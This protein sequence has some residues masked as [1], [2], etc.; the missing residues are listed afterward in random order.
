M[1]KKLWLK[2]LID[3]FIGI[4]VIIFLLPIL[5][6][7][8]ILIKIE[9]GGKIFFLQKRLG[10]DR[11][12]FKI[13]KFRTMKENA[14]DIRLADG[15]T[16]NSDD[17]PRVTKIGKFLRRTSLDEL[18]Q[19]INVIKGEMSIIGPR[20]D[21]P[22]HLKLYEGDEF[23]KLLVRPGITGYAQVNG[24]NDLPWKER[25]KYDIYY[26]ENWSIMLDMKIILKTIQIILTGKGVNRENV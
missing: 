26:A 25:F 7:I 20:P 15:S 11:K 12:I 17:D 5:F 21:L 23:K 9:D 2:D 24:R 13:Y 18:A 4:I 19:I 10:K 1:S 3:K 16:F 8:G 14:P 6:I 22:D